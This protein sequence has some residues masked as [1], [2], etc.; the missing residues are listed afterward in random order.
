MTE[1]Q[2]EK[3]GEGFVRLVRRIA[4]VYKHDLDGSIDSARERK[5]WMERLES[6]VSEGKY[7][8]M[9]MDAAFAAFLE[10]TVTYFPGSVFGR[11][12]SSAAVVRM[13]V[14]DFYECCISE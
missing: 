3:L 5:S 11:R 8:L 14:D 2:A 9:E 10:D 4:E 1:V 6:E 7:R 13:L 12:G